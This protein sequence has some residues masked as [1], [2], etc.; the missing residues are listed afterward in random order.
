MK[1]VNMTIRLNPDELARANRVCDQLG[2]TKSTLFKICYEH[3]YRKEILKKRYP[4]GGLMDEFHV[5]AET[6]GKITNTHYRDIDH[7]AIDELC[8][9]K[10]NG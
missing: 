4:I 3:L 6:I 9:G 8:G 5:T 10:D 7:A 1:K 2:I